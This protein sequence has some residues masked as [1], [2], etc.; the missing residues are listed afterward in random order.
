MLMPTATPITPQPSHRPKRTEKKNRAAMVRVTDT[1]M[2][3][4]TSPAARSPLPR[5]P[6]KG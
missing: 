5:A 6:A 3:N 4:L 2:V 1:A